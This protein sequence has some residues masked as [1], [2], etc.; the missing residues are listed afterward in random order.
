MSAYA[1]IW[2]SAYLHHTCQR[3]RICDLVSPIS[4][5]V[6]TLPPSPSCSASTHGACTRHELPNA[7]A[8]PLSPRRRR[9]DPSGAVLALG[10]LNDRPCLEAAL[11]FAGLGWPVFPVAWPTGGGTCACRSGAQCQ[12][13]AKHPLVPGGRRAATVDQRQ[14]RDWWAHWPSAGVGMLTGAPS[15]LAVLDVD[16]PPRRGRHPGPARDHQG[17][18]L[19]RH[20]YGADRRR[21]PP[22][23]PVH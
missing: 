12:H 2:T 7:P 18:Q 6:S 14:I 21:R 16:P 3:C 13:P 19:A 10:A 15:G 8:P 4:R 9:T 23:R 1:Y 17:A 5:E 20:P 22:S 11:G